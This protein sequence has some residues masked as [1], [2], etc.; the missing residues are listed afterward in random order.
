M[1][2]AEVFAEFTGSFTDDL[3]V[4][5][6]SVIH[7]RNLRPHRFNAGSVVEDALAAF[8]NMD[9]IEARILCRHAQMA[10]ASLKMRLRM[11]G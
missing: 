9:E 2:S 7:G 6:H 3:E 11:Y 10:T 4:S 1:S 5:A 8:A